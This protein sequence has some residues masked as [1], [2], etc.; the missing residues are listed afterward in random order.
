MLLLGIAI[1]ASG[2]A[3][4]NKNDKTTPAASNGLS[5]QSRSDPEERAKQ[6]TERLEDSYKKAKE[7]VEA[8]LKASKLN[9]AK[10][11][12]I[13]QKIDEI[14]NYRKSVDTTS[15]EAKKELSAKRKEWRGWAE[16]NDVSTRYFVR[17][18]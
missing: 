17:I 4:L 13:N 10:A 18:Y 1:G 7:T 6:Q 12:A 5:Q 2:Y 16:Q 11:D 3:L 14:Y 9:Q 8:D 15:E